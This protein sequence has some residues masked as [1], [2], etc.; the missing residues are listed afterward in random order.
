MSQAATEA[1]ASDA[2][3]AEA[4]GIGDEQQQEQQEQTTGE[5]PEGQEP[6]SFDDLPQETQEEIRRLRRE[7]ANLRVKSREAARKAPP[8]ENGEQ[9]A[10]SKQALK[11]AED[12][13]RDS[14]RMEFGVR[15]AGAEV[16]AALAGVLTEAQITEVV[17][18]INLARF[19]DDDGEV[20]SEAI[21]TLRDKYQALVGKRSTPK[22]SHGRQGP[23]AQ[24]KTAADQFADTLNT[25]FD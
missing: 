19:V 7:N 20:D 13:G 14:A 5:E 8:G 10:A 3:V 1:P 9:P 15:L 6:V 17:E 18:D 12:R 24:S 11:A 22:V 23:P 25:L 21:G 16:K 4:F 2:E